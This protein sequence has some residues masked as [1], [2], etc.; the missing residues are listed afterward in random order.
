MTQKR[1]PG[2]AEPEKR[3]PFVAASEKRAHT[4]GGEP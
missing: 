3:P 4:V 2:Q 1:I